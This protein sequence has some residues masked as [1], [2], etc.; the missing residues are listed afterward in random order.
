MFKIFIFLLTGFL[1]LLITFTDALS[2]GDEARRLI[3]IGTADLQGRLDPVERAV[4][5]NKDGTTT[6]VVGGISR[7]ASTIN[8][9][10]QSGEAPVIV[11]SSGD[12][13]MGSYFHFFDGKAIIELM[14]KAGYDIIGLGNHEFDRGPGV[15]GEALEKTDFTTLC[16]DLSITGTA[17]ENSC[18]PY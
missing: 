6:D 14:G 15:L 16:S 9:I 2:G 11:I 8:K 13:L 5:L 12:D 3:F 10:K 1:L 18:K 17:L 4:N 7:I